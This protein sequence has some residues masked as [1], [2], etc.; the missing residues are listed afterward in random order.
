[1]LEVI[2]GLFSIPHIITLSIMLYFVSSLVNVMLST[3]KSILTVKANK[4]VATLINALSY[5]F[6][7]VVVKQL[8]DI[9]FTTAA[10]VTFITNVIGVYTSMYLLEKIES[11]FFK[12]E[13]VW[14]ISVT[15]Y[16]KEILDELK[17]QEIPFMWEQK[18]FVKEYHKDA[19]GVSIP[20]ISSVY[21]ID[22]VSKTKEKSAVIK[23]VLKK[24]NVKHYVIPG[25]Q[26]L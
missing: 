1:M 2:K 5:S 21:S 25:V 23:E 22:I 19:S 20:V 26:E 17:R 13:K 11:K 15:A 24:Y 9:S 12:K 6:Y 3:V 18:E 10:L 14:K 4:I 7:T 16:S 8:A